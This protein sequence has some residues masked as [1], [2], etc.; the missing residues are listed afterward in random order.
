MPA[1]I[2]LGRELLH[3]GPPRHELARVTLLGTYIEERKRAVLAWIMPRGDI[4]SAR[5]ARSGG[6]GMDIVAFRSQ[7][8][9]ASRQEDLLSR[10]AQ[11][12]RIARGQR[13]RVRTRLVVTHARLTLQAES[14][15]GI[16]GVVVRR[17]H[18]PWLHPPFDDEEWD[19]AVDG[20]KADQRGARFEWG[21][22][23][24]RHSR[25]PDCKGCDSVQVRIHTRTAPSARQL[26][27]V[28]SWCGEVRPSEWPRRLAGKLFLRTGRCLRS[29]Q[30]RGGSSRQPKDAAAAQR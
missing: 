3:S 30:R 23:C 19:A 24:L 21:K 27:Q 29:Y 13:R 12:K 14:T 25:E 4:D 15:D 17:K 11:M 9:H 22:L 20:S 7:G 6:E 18:R 8:A 10:Q 1:S 28:R 16:A 5:A 26:D 2:A